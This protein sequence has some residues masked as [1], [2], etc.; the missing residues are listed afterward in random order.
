MIRA[1]ARPTNSLAATTAP[2]LRG[3]PTEAKRADAEAKIAKVEM[4][5]PAHARRIRELRCGVGKIVRDRD[6]LPVA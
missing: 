1:A 5:D 3:A 2:A 4:P 6:K